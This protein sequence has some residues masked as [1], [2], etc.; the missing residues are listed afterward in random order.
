[1]E[2]KGTVTVSKKINAVIQ[3][4][5]I[6]K[7]VLC[8]TLPDEELARKFKN[9]SYLFADGRN[10]GLRAVLPMSNALVMDYTFKAYPYEE[11]IT[12]N[13]PKCESMQH[14]FEDSKITA[15]TFT[16]GT[17]SLKL[18]N[19]LFNK[20]SKLTSI[21][22]LDLTNAETL[23]YAFNCLQM[24]TS[25]NLVSTAKATNFSYAFYNSSIT[26][27]QGLDTAS[28]TNLDG[29]FAKTNITELDLNCQNV[30]TI[31]GAFAGCTQLSSLKLSGLTVSVSVASLPL[32]A[33]ALNV[34]FTSLGET[35][36]GKIT[37]TGTT[38]A[39]TCDKTIAEQKGWTVI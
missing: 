16:N 22:G 29:A 21:T 20:C 1:M 33:E 10:V 18:S 37:I 11:S 3:T 24:L 2:I 27:I 12:I 4:R 39:A 17:K 31:K 30:T 36:T 28:A 19:H 8:P 34:L 38:G 9:I 26:Q 35:Q 25:V 6:L 14:A 32:T 5:G 23:S 13:V 7:A 15:V